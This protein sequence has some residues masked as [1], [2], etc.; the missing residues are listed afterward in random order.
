M[1]QW[2]PDG[3]PFVNT[4]VVPMNRS[5]QWTTHSFPFRLGFKVLD[6]GFQGMYMDTPVMTAVQMPKRS[7]ASLSCSRR[8]QKPCQVLSP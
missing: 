3:V 7:Y 1:S 5:V 2:Q 6:H 8:Q 4:T